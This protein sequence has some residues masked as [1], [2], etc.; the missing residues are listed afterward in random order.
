MIRG[1]VKEYNEI[2]G[3]LNDAYNADS[4]RGYEPLTDEERD[5]MTEEQIKKWEDKIKGSLLRRD[6]TLSGL[7][8]TTGKPILSLPSAYVRMIMP[9]TASCIFTAT[10]RMQRYPARRI[11]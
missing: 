5:A 9:S 4:A 8:P 2:L 11:S 3:E 7:R 6:D 1:F 10:R